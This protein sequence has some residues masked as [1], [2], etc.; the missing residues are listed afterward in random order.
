MRIQKLIICLNKIDKVDADE[1]QRQFEFA[2]EKLKDK[3]KKVGYSG[4]QISKMKFLPVSGYTGLNL[5]KK[6]SETHVSSYNSKLFTE[7]KHL[8]WYEGETLLEALENLEIP[9]KYENLPLRI[10]NDTTLKIRGAGDIWQA[11]VLSGKLDL[12]TKLKYVLRGSEVEKKYEANSIKEE[13]FQCMGKQV[14][15]AKAGDNIGFK[16]DYKYIMFKKEEIKNRGVIFYN[17]EE[18]PPQLVKSFIAEIYINDHPNKI[19]SGYSP[20][21]FCHHSKTPACFE[22]IISKSKTVLSRTVEEEFPLYVEKGDLVTVE[23]VLSKPIVLD[24]YG[25]CPPLGRFLLKDSNFLVGGGKVKE[26]LTVHQ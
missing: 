2:C 5:S 22:R 26:I 10:T 17:S 14:T 9:Q 4:R 25:K 13:F 19:F 20:V 23:I 16:V 1:S 24:E 11:T 3:L 21:L 15:E 7:S 6:G 8:D 12:N 18:A